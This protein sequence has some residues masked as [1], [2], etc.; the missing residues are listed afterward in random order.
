MG[1]VESLSYYKC[2]FATFTRCLRIATVLAHARNYLVCYLAAHWPARVTLDTRP[3]DVR[4]CV[5]ENGAGLG[6]RLQ[7]GY[8]S[9]YDRSHVLDAREIK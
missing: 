3:C 6:T 2:R 4:L 8:V 9:V 7:C 5:T 1:C